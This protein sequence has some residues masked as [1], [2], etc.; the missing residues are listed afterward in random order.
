[1]NLLRVKAIVAVALFAIGC[2]ANVD[3]RAPISQPVPPTSASETVV[4]EALA[5]IDVDE[6]LDEV[7]GTQCVRLGRTGQPLDGRDL[8]VP[9]GSPSLVAVVPTDARPDSALIFVS[10]PEGWV[11]QSMESYNERVDTRELADTVVAVVPV[12][13]KD[14]LRFDLDAQTP[15]GEHIRCSK[16][17]LRLECS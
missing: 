8:C 11:V 6:W 16:V 12:S 3:D 7:S 17:G 1:M 13:S 15:G 2:G 5:R 10:L 9:R 4:D 14:E